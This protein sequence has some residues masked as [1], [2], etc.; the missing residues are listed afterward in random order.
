MS[1]VVSQLELVSIESKVDS[2]E[3]QV[4]YIVCAFRPVVPVGEIN[5]FQPRTRVFFDNRELPDGSTIKDHL[6]SAFKSA[7]AGAKVQGKVV[8]LP[9]TPYELNSRTVTTT[10][11]VC[12]ANENEVTV[13]NRA[14]KEN[15]AHVVDMATGE[16]FENIPAG[17]ES[18]AQ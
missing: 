15:N 9:T 14:L 16:V 5:P 18:V 8:T 7:K 10:T 12:F 3:Q 1:E 2:S 13:A 4:P 11:I 6:Y 17:A